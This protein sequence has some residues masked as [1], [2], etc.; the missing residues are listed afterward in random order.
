[1]TV[2]RIK[3]I[4]GIL[5]VIGL[6]LMLGEIGTAE[7]MDRLGEPYKFNYLQVIIG[8]LMAMP[9]PIISEYVDE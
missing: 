9:F 8:F 2:R 5:M 6:I 7:I 4:T 1:M 3:L